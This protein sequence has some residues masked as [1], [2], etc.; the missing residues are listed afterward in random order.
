[1]KRLWCVA[2]LFMLI[3]LELEAFPCYVTVV[4]DSCWLNYNV[5]ITVSDMVT[6]QVVTNVLIPKGQTW[7]RGEFTCQA[8]QKF[9][10]V[11][12]FLPVIWQNDAGKTYRG[13][14]SWGLPVE[15]DPAAVAWELKLCYA[16]DF[17]ETPL[18]VEAEG[19]CQCDF[20]QVTP[21]TP[22]K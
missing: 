12:S 9:L 19:N 20:T 8:N 16:A 10:Y 7:A 6:Q 4:K 5:T 15:F 11:A 18:P 22:T 2:F 13:L 17:S 21:I 3:P 14:R 1:M